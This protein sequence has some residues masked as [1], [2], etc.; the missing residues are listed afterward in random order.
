MVFEEGRKHFSMYET[1][2]GA[3]TVGV[4]ARRVQSSLSDTG[5]DIELVYA[6]EIDH[7][8]AGENFFQINVREARTSIPQ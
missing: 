2:Y 1:P 8:V 6:V 5:G 7:A 4:S 3:M